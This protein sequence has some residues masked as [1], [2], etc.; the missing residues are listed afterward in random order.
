MGVLKHRS[1]ADNDRDKGSNSRLLLFFLLIE[2]LPLSPRGAELTR[3]IN[4]VKATRGD[5]L[6]C[7]PELSMKAIALLR[8]ALLVTN[9]AFCLMSGC[10]IFEEGLCS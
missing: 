7:C 4:S 2:G 9:N 5:R 10:L 8:A 3:F 6:V 1:H